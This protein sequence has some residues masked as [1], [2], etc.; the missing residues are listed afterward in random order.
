MLLQ[1]REIGLDDDD[2]AS[3][4]CAG[5]VRRCGQSAVCAEVGLLRGHGSGSHRRKSPALILQR[6]GVTPSFRRSGAPFGGLAHSGP[7][8]RC[9]GPSTPRRRLLTV[10]AEGDD[11]AGRIRGLSRRAS[12]RPSCTAIASCSTASTPSTSMGTENILAMGV[13]MRASHQVQVGRPAGRRRGRRQGRH[14]LARARHAG[15]GP[16]ADAH[17]PRG[18]PGAGLDPEAAALGTSAGNERGRT[19]GHRPSG[20]PLAGAHGGD[21]RPRV[22]QGANGR[23]RGRLPRRSGAR[24]QVATCIRAPSN[25]DAEAEAAFYGIVLMP[26]EIV[27][28]PA[29]PGSSI[30][31]VKGRKARNDRPNRA[32]IARPPRNRQRTP[33][34]LTALITRLSQNHD[35]HCGHY[36]RDFLYAPL[37]GGFPDGSPNGSRATSARFCP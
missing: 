30:E 12:T 24:R 8:C 26:H 22:R 6:F 27:G 28:S 32:I 29:G 16:P 18:R 10:V 25:A 19:S 7:P 1:Q 23:T 14:G 33:S 4:R 37:T 35:A 2:A 15:R 5:A 17:L 13:R 9:T 31:A 21:P 34:R 11:H 20:A 3:V 36:C